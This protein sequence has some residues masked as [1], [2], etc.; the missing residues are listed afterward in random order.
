MADRNELDR[1]MEKAGLSDED[2][3]KMRDVNDKQ[4]TSDKEPAR[5][6]GHGAAAPAVSVVDDL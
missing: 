1:I 4:Q 6:R 3:R 2:R 5:P